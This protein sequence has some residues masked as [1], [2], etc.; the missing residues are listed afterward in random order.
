MSRA[1]RKVLASWLSAS[2]AIVLLVSLFLPWTHQLSTHLLGIAGAAAAL[3]GVPSD[4]TAWQVYSS[5]DAL[6]ALIAA[7]V[8]VVA[9]VGPRP[10]R[11]V[12]VLATALALAF[13]V[14]AAVVPPTNGL[15]N[16]F[17]ALLS[18]SNLRRAVSPGPGVILAIIALVVATVGLELSL[19]AD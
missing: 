19:T 18:E 11:I 17:P 6:L 3:R 9:L 8:F 1:Q 14:H 13:V 4:P 15:E 16:V 7:G 10:S 2:G 5:V 12:A